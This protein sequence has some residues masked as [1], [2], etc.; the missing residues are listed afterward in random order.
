MS[1]S[2][3]W[4]PAVLVAA[5]ALAV[6]SS[7]PANAHGGAQSDAYPTDV[8][9]A[10]KLRAAANYCREAVRAWDRGDPSQLADRRLVKARERLATKW[11]GAEEAALAAGVS[12][13]DTTATSAEM[14][15][16]LDSG[17]EDLA[18]AIAT[19]E[20]ASPE[21]GKRHGRDECDERD[22]HCKHDGA[23]AAERRCE[24]SRNQ[25]VAQACQQLLAA[26]ARHLR[27]RDTDRDREKLESR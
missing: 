8:C 24:S 12:C 27:H 16:V 26:D 2:H 3:S 5:T 10:H 13:E 1:H 4:S 6:V 15:S 22:K 14:I 25:L 19:S 21:R 11:D 7:L 9:V 23:A 17:A 20:G 18:A